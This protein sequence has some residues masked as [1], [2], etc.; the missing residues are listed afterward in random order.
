[1]KIVGGIMAI[2][3]GLIK[4]CRNDP[5]ER[6]PKEGTPVGHFLLWWLESKTSLHVHATLYRI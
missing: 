1:M 3:A 5:R 4:R 2:V 6:A